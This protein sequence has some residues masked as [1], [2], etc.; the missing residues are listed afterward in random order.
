MLFFAQPRMF[1]YPDHDADAHAILSDESDFEEIKISYGKNQYLHGW[2]KHN[3]DSDEPAPLIIFFGGNAMN[4]STTSLWYLD[5]S[6]YEYFEGY[7]FLMMD[8]PGYG[9]STG[10]PSDKSMYEAALTIYDYVI[11]MENVDE[12]NIVVK[13]FSIGSGVATHLASKRDV[14]GLILLAPFDRG[15]SLYN[16]VLNIFY[17]PLRLLARYNFN[18]IEYAQNVSVQPLII[19]SYGDEMMNSEWPKNLAEY[20]NEVYDLVM[21]DG[22]CHNLILANPTTLERVNTYLSSLKDVE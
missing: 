4:S 5:S 12:N 16:S 22:V 14:N 6:I 7:N 11:N 17:G 3:V 9:L 18:S 15:L 21:L 2:F 10:R 20:F 19:A 13:G 1:F 8:Y